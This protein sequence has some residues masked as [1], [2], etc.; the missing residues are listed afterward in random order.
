M[1]TLS[2]APNPKI[3]VVVLLI[4]PTTSNLQAGLV[5]PIPTFPPLAPTY[6]NPL[7]IFNF[8]FWFE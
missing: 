3:S 6:N 1:L 5:E 2:L 4:V 8:P 7:L